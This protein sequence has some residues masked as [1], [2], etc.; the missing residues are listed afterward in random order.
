MD[1]IKTPMFYV[2]SISA[3]LAACAPVF[4]VTVFNMRLNPPPHKKVVFEN[5]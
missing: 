3:V 4:I 2:A 5:E 1:F